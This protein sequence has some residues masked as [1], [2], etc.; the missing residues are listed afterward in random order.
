MSEFCF[1]C[2]HP[3][4][5]RNYCRPGAVVELLDGTFEFAVNYESDAGPCPDCGV[6]SGSTHH[7]CCDQERCPRCG[8]Q[9]LLCEL[10]GCDR[11]A[12]EQH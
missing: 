5:G 4:I 3:I 2:Q 6:V 11:T 12:L 7:Q 10:L 1:R 8:G 9:W